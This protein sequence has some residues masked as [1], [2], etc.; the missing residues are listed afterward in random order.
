[1]L[2]EHTRNRNIEGVRGCIAKGDD[3]DQVD[4]DGQTALMYAS[5]DGLLD[6]VDALIKA[7]ANVS[8]LS[9]YLKTP[10]TYAAKCGHISV[11]EKLMEAGADIDHQDDEG[12]TPLMHAIFYSEISMFQFLLNSGS[13]LNLRS[14]NRQYSALIIALQREDRAMI[15]PLLLSDKVDVND[16]FYFREHYLQG[17]LKMK[18]CVNFIEDHYEQLASENLQLWKNIRLKGLFS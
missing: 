1:M 8:C 10:L 17:L 7:G 11:A 4:R 15:E 2:I 14:K 13:N 3:L 12:W 16:F 18:L 6:I 9:R 5:R